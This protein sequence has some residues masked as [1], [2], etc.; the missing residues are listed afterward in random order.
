[1]LVILSGVAGSGKDTIKLELMKR[2]SNLA[3][4]KSYTTRKPREDKEDLN[5]YF[6]VT[7]EEFVDLI[8]Q[9]KL[10]EYSMHHDNYYGTSKEE[11]DSKIADGK[12]VIKDIDVNGTKELINIFKNKLK[13]ISIFLKV[14]KE[15][16][17]RRLIERGE[18]LESAEKRLSRQEYEESMLTLYD[19][20]VYNNDLEKTL[21]IIKQ[22]IEE[23]YKLK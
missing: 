21:N 2:M 23:E 17:H 4:I 19:Y 6:F 13:T 14:D 7:Q 11:L 1:M 18:T 15:E 5:R 9:E 16:L 22:I 3:T 10:Y 20:V 8:N 12:I